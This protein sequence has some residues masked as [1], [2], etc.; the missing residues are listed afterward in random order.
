M[1]TTTTTKKK[2]GRPKKEIPQDQF[3]KLCAMQC[4]QEEICSFFE[5]TDK[6]LNAWCKRTY[7]KSFSEIYG[8]KKQLGKI[9]LRRAGWKLAQTKSAVHIFYAKNFLGMSDN[10]D[11][12][13]DRE[14][15]QAK[16]E[17][18]QAQTAKIKGED[19][20]IEDITDIEVGIYGEKETADDTL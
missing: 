14:L 15:Q 13:P 2:T 16:L 6:T 17:Y 18:L 20:E 12:K 3:E 9:S 4:T 5:V 11:V 10:P 7:K 8:E 1:A 19:Q